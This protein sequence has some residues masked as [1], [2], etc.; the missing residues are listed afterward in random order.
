MAL[1]KEFREEAIRRLKANQGRGD[2][3]AAH[4]DSDDVLLDVLSVLGY[5]DIIQEYN[6]VAKWYP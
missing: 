6:K 3:E 5:D 4:V 1:S 2:M